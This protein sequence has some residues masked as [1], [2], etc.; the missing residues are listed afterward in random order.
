MGMLLFFYWDLE[1]MLSTVAKSCHPDFN[2]ARGSTRLL[3]LN[4]FT[5]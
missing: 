2:K 3:I 4:S 5:M 1:L